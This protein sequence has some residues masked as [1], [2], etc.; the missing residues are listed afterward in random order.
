MHMNNQSQ[1]QKL[2]PKQLQVADNIPGAE[3]SNMMQVAHNRDEFQL[4]FMNVF[5]NS[6]RVAGK[7]ITNPGHYKRMVEA[8]KD[9]LK[10]YE[11]KF[12]IIKEADAP[13]TEIGFKS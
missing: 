12:G 6:G 11:E 13:D 1:A 9:N 2:P 10:K 5:M 4:V 3:Y 7:I 8:L